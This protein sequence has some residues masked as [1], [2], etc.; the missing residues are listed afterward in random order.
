MSSFKSTDKMQTVADAIPTDAAALA[1]MRGLRRRFGD[2]RHAVKLIAQSHGFDPRTVTGWW[3]GRNPP[4]TGALLTLIR[5]IDEVHE[6]ILR[7]TG[8]ENA[9]DTAA[10]LSRLRDGAEEIERVMAKLSGRL[11]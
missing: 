7:L 11:L 9:A 1:V 4:Q 6:E 3:C 2:L 5:D 10:A 8:R